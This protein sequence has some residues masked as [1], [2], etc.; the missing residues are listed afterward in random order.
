MAE[1]EAA[2]NGALWADRSGS[3]KAVGPLTGLLKKRRG[4][5][6]FQFSGLALFHTGI[7]EDIRPSDFHI[8]KDILHRRLHREEFKVFSDPKTLIYKG[9]DIPSYLS[10]SGAVLAKIFS[11]PVFRERVREIFHRFDPKDQIIGLRLGLKLGRR[12]KMH[13][14]CPESVQGAGFLRGKGFAVLG[15]KVRLHNSF[16]QNAVIGPHQTY[17][18]VLQNQALISQ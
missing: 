7:L 6:P 9:D 17:Q 10:A 5:K 3:L 13:L 12:L 15:S 11:K 4:L 8:F 18:G 2:E 1:K 16:L 14:L